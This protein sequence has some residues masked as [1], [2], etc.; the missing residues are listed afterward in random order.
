M[1]TILPQKRWTAAQ[2]LNH[3]F[4]TGENF[5]SFIQLQPQKIFI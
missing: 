2:L 1:I 4:I 3:P 5:D